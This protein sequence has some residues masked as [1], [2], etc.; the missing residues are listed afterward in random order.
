MC[1]ELLAAGLR[2][3]ILDFSEHV[4]QGQKPGGRGRAKA[5]LMSVIDFLAYGIHD[6]LVQGVHYLGAV[7][8]LILIAMCWPML[9][10]DLPRL[11]AASVSAWCGRN[12]A[13]RD[14][15]AE[16]A[17]LSANPSVSVIVPAYNAGDGIEGTVVSLLETGLPNLQLIVVDDNSADG[18]YA[19]LRP[20]CERG[21]VQLVKNSAASGRAGKP[22]ALNL[23]LVYA[24]G[25]FVVFIDAD[26]TVDHDSIARMIGP[27]HDKRVGAVA[28]NVVVRNRQVNLLTFQQTAEYKLGIELCRRWLDRSGRVLGVSGAWFHAAITTFA[29]LTAAF[30]LIKIAAVWRPPAA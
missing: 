2:P 15:P 19:R 27:F 5:Y 8:P 10:L 11:I 9:L 14:L 13:R 1:S 17:F 28:G 23:G 16:R 12:T 7:H 3:G 24:T 25:E 22:A 20:W 6:L 29:V 4:N 21:V 18:M 30:M 26:S